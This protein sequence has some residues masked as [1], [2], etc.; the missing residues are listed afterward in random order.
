MDEAILESIQ[1]GQSLPTVRFYRW[2]PACLSIGY[3]QEIDDVDTKMLE[4]LGWDLV[5]R[6]TGGKA[7][8]HT[9]ELTYS[10]IGP[11]DG[12]IFSGGVLPSYERI[13]RALTAGLRR[14]GLQVQ[15]VQP[16]HHETE[17][18]TSINPENPVCFM[19]PGA[20]EITAAG[21]KLIGSAQLRRGGAVLQHGSLPLAGDIGRICEALRYPSQIERVSA[22]KT[23][24]DQAATLESVL[25]RPVKWERVARAL[26]AGFEEILSIELSAE[27]LTPLEERR[28]EELVVSRF[29]HPDWTLRD[30]RSRTYT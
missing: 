13:G 8:L 7:I 18:S 19:N 6:A 26:T 17:S 16:P 3:A 1:A 28:R 15:P 14:L 2:T 11:A 9:D 21:K 20:F 27:P 12:P 24:R 30:A 22:T 23:V 4:A 10:I 25:G 29:S 5:R